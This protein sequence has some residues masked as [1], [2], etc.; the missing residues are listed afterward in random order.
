MK[1]EEYDLNELNDAYQRFVG[2]IIDIQSRFLKLRSRQ[3]QRQSTEDI[4]KVRSTILSR[5]SNRK[6]T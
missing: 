4:D 5:I 2:N 6:N 1:K 3:D